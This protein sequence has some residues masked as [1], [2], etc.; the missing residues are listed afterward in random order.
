[1]ITR[2]IYPEICKKLD[3]KK[4]LILTGARQVGKTTLLETL[5]DMVMDEGATVHFFTL[6]DPDIL[7][8]FNQHPDKLFS[9]I[10]RGKTC[11][12]LI[13]EIQYLDD[14]SNFLK[15][16][17]D[18]HK[19]WLKLVVTGSSAFYLD[20]KFRDSLAGRKWIIPIHPFSFSEFLDAKGEEKY[21]QIIRKNSLQFLL[22][23][24][25]VLLNPQRKILNELYLEYS[26]YGGYPEVVTCTEIEEKK[27]LLKELHTSLLKKDI[28]DSAIQ[29]E[30]KF[31]ILVKILASQVGEMVNANEIAGTL[32][33]SRDTVQH[34]LFV[35]E[36][37]FVIKLV[38]P[39]H[40]NLRK[41]LTK[42]PK[43]YFLDPGYRNSI[44]KN[45]QGFNDR[46]DM[47][48]YLENIFLTEMCRCP[49]E[50]IKFWRTQDKNEVDFVVNEQIAFEAKATL[51]S[52]K[53]SKYRMFCKTHPEISLHPIT[54]HDPNSLEL[55]DFA[56]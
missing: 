53:K 21:S 3:G 24:K 4:I 16:H 7:R 56:S 23:Q 42:M 48:G 45:F 50:D 41:E 29:N 33:L 6:E 10:P 40:R 36:K 1:M 25:R 17:Y 9:Y 28:Y 22:G 34:Y 18:L 35:L 55:L 43:V 52:F 2:K 5:R 26:T 49:I 32:Q 51:Q 47:G 46:M 38:R 27:E 11:Y 31:F 15:Y 20:H 30:A 19:D 44:L 14:P 54:L 39:F 13:D 37:S 12:L 8:D